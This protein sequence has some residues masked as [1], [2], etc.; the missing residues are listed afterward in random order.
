MPIGALSVRRD[1]RGAIVIGPE[2]LPPLTLGWQVLAW[3]IDYLLQ[4]DGPEAGMPLRFTPEQVR[5]F[6]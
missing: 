1:E 4:P 3:T 2:G 6:R 5:I